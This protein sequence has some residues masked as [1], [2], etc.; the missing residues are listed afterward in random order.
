[1]FLAIIDVNTKWSQIQKDIHDLYSTFDA[2]LIM[3]A[4]LSLTRKSASL[5]DF[6]FELKHMEFTAA[7]IHVITY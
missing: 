3:C 5:D 2:F 7:T 6:K 1:M 4:L